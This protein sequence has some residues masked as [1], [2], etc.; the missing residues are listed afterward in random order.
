MNSVLRLIIAAVTIHGIVQYP[1]EVNWPLRIGV[2]DIAE[3][4]KLKRSKGF[5]STNEYHLLEDEKRDKSSA[6]LSG[7]RGHFLILIKALHYLLKTPNHQSKPQERFCKVIRLALALHFLFLAR[8]TSLAGPVALKSLANGLAAPQPQFLWKALLAFV[9]ARFLT[10]AFSAAQDAIFARAG[11]EAERAAALELF[12]H[13]QSLGPDFHLRRKTGAVVRAV[14]RGASSF[15]VVTQ[16]LFFQLLPILI[17]VGIVS[18]Y[19]LLAYPWWLTMIALAALALYMLYTLTTTEWRNQYRRVMNQKDNDFNQKAVDAL[20]NFETVK[21]FNAERH[22]IERYDSALREYAIANGDSQQILALLST[23]QEFVISLGFASVLYVTGMLVVSGK[24]NLTIGDFL[25]IQELL[26]SLFQPLSSLGKYYRSLKKSLIDIE[27][28]MRLLKEKITVQDDPRAVDLEIRQGKIEFQNVSFAYSNDFPILKSISFTVEHGQSLGIVGLSGAGKST[29]VRLL[30][31][32][33]DVQ[34]G[35]ILIDGQDISH[36]TQDSLR[37]AIGIVPQDCALFNDSISYNI[38]YGMFARK[39]Q[40]A[41][42]EEIE[43]AAK[44]ASIHEFIMSQPK[45][46]ET[47]VGERGLRSASFLDVFFSESC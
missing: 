18:V 23:G 40:G 41:S 12:S 27:S 24:N 2:V 25:L 9:G 20:L 21:Y 35:R 43:Q 39:P 32:F 6:D 15:A 8:F 14:S 30:Y 4:G 29:I 7:I 47:P 5:K 33:Y 11:A 3:M 22:E 46:Y 17:Q 38:G 42:A 44:L 26:S 34:A 28:M 13:L 19:L 1:A 16:I 10:A 36:V 37:K 45:Q 31:R